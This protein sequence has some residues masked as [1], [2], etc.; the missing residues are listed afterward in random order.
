[1]GKAQ[2]EKMKRERELIEIA[3]KT[4]EDEN[5]P[6]ARIFIDM[7]GTL[8]EFEYVD[9]DVLYAPGYFEN[10]APNEPVL[11]GLKDFIEFYNESNKFEICILSNYLVDH[12]TAREEKLAWLDK[13]APFLKEHGCKI[14][15]N[16]CGESKRLA[17]PGFDARE[18]P[19]VNIL[20]DDHSPNLLDFCGYG[21]TTSEK[22]GKILGNEGIK[23][24]NKINGSGTKWKLS[25]FFCKTPEAFSAYLYNEVMKIVSRYAPKWGPAGQIN[26]IREEIAEKIVKE[27]EAHGE[28]C[29]DNP[30]FEA[31]R[32]ALE[33]LD[34]ACYGFMQQYST[35]C[36]EAEDILCI[37]T[38]LTG[39]ELDKTF[40]KI[41]NV[42]EKN[43]W[44]VRQ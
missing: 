34:R 22:D 10:L 21:D 28:E 20:L 32:S 19:V 29:Y 8:T 15:L 41:R 18:N 2:I 35:L 7:D 37:E 16:P 44:F 43:L 6:L 26:E 11:L 9:R 3:N 36:E 42:A 25:K 27:S 31:W 17:V 38:G 4:R 13:H 5:F 1:M 12:N 39:E 24:L 14:I 40:S 33:I 30:S 23:V